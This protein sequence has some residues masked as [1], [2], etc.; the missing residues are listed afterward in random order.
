MFSKMFENIGGKLK[1]FAEIITL[2]GFIF[3]ALVALFGLFSGLEMDSMV[4]VIGGV[5]GGGL[6]FLGAWI[7][8]L[9]IYAFG[10]LVEKTTQI[11]INTRNNSAE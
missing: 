7:G 1:K 3:G 8:S 2:I 5:L 6:I 4:A 9:T 10:E 11:E